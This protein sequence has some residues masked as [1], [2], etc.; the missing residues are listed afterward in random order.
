MAK[1]LLCSCL[2]LS[3]FEFSCLLSLT[4]WCFPKLARKRLS[5]W[6]LDCTPCFRHWLPQID[7]TACKA[8][9]LPFTRSRL[10]AIKNHSEV[11]FSLPSS[12]L[13][14]VRAPHAYTRAQINT[15]GHQNQRS[16]PHSRG[17]VN[18]QP[19]HWNQW[20][21]TPNRTPKQPD[22]LWLFL[23]Y[24]RSRKNETSGLDCYTQ[25][26]RSEG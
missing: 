21:K 13:Q 19:W 2:F 23:Q 17:Q 26:W 15:D 4:S 11:S 24:V 16:N 14:I 1:C 20:D 3:S 6:V 7:S 12:A 22:R 9:L 18:I 25:P 10:C 5:R 8:F